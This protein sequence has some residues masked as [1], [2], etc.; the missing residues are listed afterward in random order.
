MP[1]LATKEFALRFLAFKE[2]VTTATVTFTNDN[3]DEY[4][5]HRLTLT[6][7]P[8]GIQVCQVSKTQR[9]TPNSTRLGPTHSLVAVRA[10][11][12]P[13]I[14]LSGGM[15]YAGE[16]EIHN[17][18]TWHAL[19]VNTPAR[20]ELT[21]WGADRL[22][23]CRTY[24]PRLD[25]N[26]RYSLMYAQETIEMEGSVRS[27]TRRLITVANPLGSDEPITFPQ[28]SPADDLSPAAGSGGN[29]EVRR[30]G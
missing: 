27:L 8:P 21:A 15:C 11:G 10:P 17:V 3:T 16:G 13:S 19:C 23:F 4:L 24:L 1:A 20:V 14:T 2:G 26:S 30:A 7:T 18:G 6:A 28:R 22:S 25:E 9:A 5:F 29:S 12:D